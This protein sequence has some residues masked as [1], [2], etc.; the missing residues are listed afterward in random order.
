MLESKAASGKDDINR[1]KYIFNSE[2]II[3]TYLNSS[4]AK[5]Q[6]FVILKAQTFCQRPELPLPHRKASALKS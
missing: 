3:P 1:T 4:R 6:S 5:Q 2:H